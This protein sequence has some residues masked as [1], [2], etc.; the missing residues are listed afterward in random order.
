MEQL[1]FEDYINPNI[2]HQKDASTI[3]TLVIKQISRGRFEITD[4]I[5]EVKILLKEEK[6]TVILSNTIKLQEFREQTLLVSPKEP[7]LD[8]LYNKIGLNKE[9]LIEF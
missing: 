5:C 4:N 1:I 6:R 8:L 3:I 7:S 9:P 2:G